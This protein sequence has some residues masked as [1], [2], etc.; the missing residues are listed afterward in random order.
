MQRS[1]SP[2][3]AHQRKKSP[4][5]YSPRKSPFARK[6]S[7]KK[8]RRSPFACGSSPRKASPP[9]KLPFACGS[10]PKGSRWAVTKSPRMSP[11]ARGPSPRK[12]PF[13]VKS[14]K[15]HLPACYQG[16]GNNNGSVCRQ[17]QSEYYN[18]P[19]YGPKTKDGRPMACDPN[20]DETPQPPCYWGYRNTIWGD[21]C[22]HNPFQ[23]KDGKDPNIRCMGG[24]P[25]CLVKPKYKDFKNSVSKTSAECYS[26]FMH[27]KGKKDPI[28]RR[29]LNPT[30]YSNTQC[31]GPK[32]KDG[33]RPKSCDLTN[34]L[35]KEQIALLAVEIC[36]DYHN[37]DF[38]N[39]SASE[40]YIKLMEN[41]KKNFQ[42]TTGDEVKLMAKIKNT[43]FEEIKFTPEEAV[44]FDT[45]IKLPEE[46][47]AKA[48]EEIQ[49]TNPQILEK[50]EKATEVG[51]VISRFT[52][53][54]KNNKKTS[55]AIASAA[56]V[57]GLLATD[58]LTSGFD[59]SETKSAK[60]L[61]KGLE[62][63]KGLGETYNYVKEGITSAKNIVTGAGQ[64]L[65]QVKTVVTAPYNFV[66]SGVTQ[67]N[68]FANW[69]TSWLPGGT[70][71]D[72]TQP[73]VKDD[74]TAAVDSSVP[75]KAKGSSADTK[76]G[77]SSAAGLGALE[78]ASDT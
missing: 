58:L 49:K 41:H 21:K 28:C 25:K 1:R 59:I 44:I 12:S 3:A 4:R 11:F 50:L 78:G 67:A 24:G 10:S 18:K 27:G 19:C 68:R 66:K 32:G 14:M 38:M 75:E 45:A 69:I 34:T 40:K 42:L 15:Y 5:G 37:Q 55:A 31:F 71:L 73:E 60:I 7:P 43:C 76:A 46:E 9:R 22:Q 16:Y 62:K 30:K 51:G 6:S 54:V 47:Q 64:T 65:S 36:K 29:L 8:G 53:F 57:T 13:A 70:V 17:T 33:K 48:F 63:I 2:F 72:E 39:L 56:A 23:M 35:T 52:D 74:S 61:N 20:L 26:G 77:I